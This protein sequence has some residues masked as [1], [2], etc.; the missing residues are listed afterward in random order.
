ML[1][2]ILG[3]VLVVMKLWP[4]A[5]IGL[6][7][8]RLLV[9]LPLE[10]ADHVD[11]RDMILLGL[12]LFGGQVVALLGPDLA[13][14]YAMDLSFYAEAVVATTMTAAAARLRY[15]WRGLTVLKRVAARALSA[16]RPRGRT[17]RTKAPPAHQSSP[18]NDDDRAGAWLMRAA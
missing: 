18:C 7:L 10:L 1:T 6:W 2:G 14:V 12:I 13:L 8:H 16:G 5:P 11:R 15:T 3:L 9:E 17:R 4:R